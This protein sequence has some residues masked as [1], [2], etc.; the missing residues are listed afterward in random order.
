MM[1]SDSHKINTFRFVSERKCG[2]IAAAVYLL[3]VP[4]SLFAGDPFRPQSFHYYKNIDGVPAER[5]TGENAPAYATLQIDEEIVRY[6]SGS[7]I[8]VTLNDRPLPYFIRTVESTEKK[9]KMIPAVIYSKTTKAGQISVLK[10]ERLPAE[11]CYTKLK[12][13][14]DKEYEAG[15]YLQYSDKPDHWNSL[16]NRTVFHYAGTELNQIDLGCIHAAYLRI[17]IDSTESFRFPEIYFANENRK[18]RH[19]HAISPDEIRQ[20]ANS[21]HNSTLFYYENPGRSRINRLVLTFKE[22]MF[23]RRFEI[24]SRD[25]SSKKYSYFMSGA[26]SR[27]AENAKEQTIDFPYTNSDPIRIEIFNED[28]EPLTLSSV[29][30]F[31]PQEELVFRLPPDEL[32]RQ[33]TTPVFRIYYGNEYASLPDYDIREIYDETL[34]H[35]SLE[36][37]EHTENQAFAWTALEP[38]VSAWIIRIL[39]FLGFFTIS[40]PAFRILRRYRMELS[41]NGTN[42]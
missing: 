1:K 2:W 18:K 10:L 30:A 26:I 27:S 25:R 20:T 29:F 15:M 5:L 16:G 31:S 17:S 9:G 42:S 19:E 38:P 23:R 14:S 8:R 6:S 33:T 37:G 39:F 13:A 41:R 21:D 24:Y 3:S 35:I 7:D 40:L 4:V 32:I 36:A 12:I 34:S 11:K 28:N 22:P